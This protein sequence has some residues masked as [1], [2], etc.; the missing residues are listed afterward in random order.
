MLI[1]EQFQLE[2]LSR[3]FDVNCAVVRQSHMTVK[4]Y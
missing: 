1:I 2:I 3:K 4:M